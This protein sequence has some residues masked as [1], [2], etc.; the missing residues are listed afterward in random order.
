MATVIKFDRRFFSPKGAAAGIPQMGVTGW[1][2]VPHGSK[3]WRLQLETTRA[4]PVVKQLQR[5]F[6]LYT[7]RVLA[8]DEDSVP[9]TGETE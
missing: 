9:N 6:P 7:F 8:S 5:L 2:V 4:V 1:R 3:E